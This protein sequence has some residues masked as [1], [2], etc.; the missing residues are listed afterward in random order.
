MARSGVRRVFIGLES[1]NPANL[2]AVGKHHN[3]LKE[4]RTM[5]MKWR[6]HGVLTFAGY[7]LGF[8]NDTYESIMRDVDYLKRELPLDHPEF[9][10]LTPLPGSEDHRRMAAEGVALD[11]D[12]NNYDASHVCMPHPRMSKQELERAYRDAWK[13]FYSKDHMRTLLLRKKGPRR[14]ILMNSL[15]WFCV[16]MHLD[17]MHPLMGGFFRFKGRKDRRPG[18]PVESFLPYYAKRLKEILCYVAGLLD[19]FLLLV[20][21]KRE[22]NR[23]ENADY[24]DDAIK[25]LEDERHTPAQSSEPSATPKVNVEQPNAV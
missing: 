21:L 1:V 11:P 7:I 6:E 13:S 4:Y 17:K 23:P 19:I 10:I 2:K 20:R 15:L 25:P 5:L 9:F 14:R 24:T 8:P 12:V 3:Q 16:T 22:A 18:M